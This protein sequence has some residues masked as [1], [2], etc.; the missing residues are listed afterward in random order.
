M[1][2]FSLSKNKKM[3]LSVPQS[4]IN[5]LD[6][7]IRYQNIVLIKEIFK[8][9]NWNSDELIEKLINSN[10]NEKQKMKLKPSNLKY[11]NDK[12]CHIRTREALKVDNIEYMLEYPT[13][14]VYLNRKYVGR[15][16]DER[17]DEDY[18]EL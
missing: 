11:S 1:I 13:D 2:S 3:D 15:Y 18:N 5:N 16:V 10:L 14:N 6:I 8:W 7:V 17:I 9:K 12:E 4:F